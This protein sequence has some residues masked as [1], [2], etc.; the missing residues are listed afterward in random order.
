MKCRRFLW[1]FP[2]IQWFW[3]APCWSIP[4]HRW[5]CRSRDWRKRPGECPFFSHLWGGDTWMT[6]TIGARGRQ[7]FAW[8]SFRCCHDDIHRSYIYN[9][10]SYTCTLISFSILFMFYKNFQHRRTGWWPKSPW[11]LR[12]VLDMFDSTSQPCCW[13]DVQNEGCSFNKFM[14][15][16]PISG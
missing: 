5:F 11:C 15:F 16:P 12:L 3:N 7:M 14:F 4:P 1:N 6:M 13:I 2:P 8:I 10:S 9:I